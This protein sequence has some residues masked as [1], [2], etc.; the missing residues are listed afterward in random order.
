MSELTINIYQT[1]IKIKKFINIIESPQVKREKNE[2]IIQNS[3]INKNEKKTKLKLNRIIF[4]YLMEKKTKGKEDRL[5]F[6]WYGDHILYSDP[7]LDHT[8]EGDIPF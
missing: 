6:G 2:D 7:P 3:I 5:E 1:R 4:H 8:F